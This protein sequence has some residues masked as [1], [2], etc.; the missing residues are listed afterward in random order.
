MKIRKTMLSF[1]FLVLMIFALG[2]IAGKTAD[3]DP[4]VSLPKA[5]FDA[6]AERTGRPLNAISA[7]MPKNL[8]IIENEAFEGTALA[9]V[10][11]PDKVSTIGNRA[12]ANAP[13]LIEVY[14]PESTVQIGENAF[15]EDSS[16]LNLKA[17]HGSYAQEWARG[18][19]IGFVLLEGIARRKE[20][21]VAAL[22]AGD[23]NK[24]IFVSSGIRS[25]SSSEK[26]ERSTGRSADDLKGSVYTGKDSV[27]VRSRY[28]P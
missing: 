25:V 1:G 6:A 24:K 28:F 2:V 5:I 4:G 13:F 21:V 8:E 12:F 9:K 3:P 14:I 26:Q 15:D 27:Y 7:V 19:K 18:K 17:F 16:C 23:R 20:T 22:Q 10:V 11:L